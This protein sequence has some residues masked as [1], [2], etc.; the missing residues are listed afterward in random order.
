MG[1]A[2]LS[3]YA[4]VVAPLVLA[5][6]VAYLGLLGTHPKFQSYV[7]AQEAKGDRAESSATAEQAARRLLAA[8]P[9]PM[10]R[11]F[12]NL[13]TRCRELQQIS[14]AIREPDDLDDAEPLEEMHVAGL[15]RLLWIYL[16]LLYT[17]DALDRFLK[18]TSEKD[19]ERSI[20]VLEERIADM[21]QAADDIPRQRMRKSLEDN[22]ETS[23]ARL[24]NYN[25]ARENSELVA[26][27]IDRLENKI[28]SLSEMAVNRHEPGFVSSQVDQVAA[29]L[30]HAERTM[31]DL[32]FLTGIKAAEEGVPELLRRPQ[33]TT[34]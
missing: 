17:Q 16:R 29:S 21:G 4:D 22:L 27:E 31:S 13:R 9:E 25:K 1:F 5:G 19:L 14:R 15:D 7:N 3:G 10:A 18:Q 26:L 12:E 6:E 28:R 8:L 33:V 34:H 30:E 20:K 24:A 23:R 32:Q 2:M 11:R